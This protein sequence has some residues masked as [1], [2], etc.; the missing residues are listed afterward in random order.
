MT[1]IPHDRTT[2]TLG[3]V[4]D[5]VNMVKQY[6]DIVKVSLDMGESIHVHN[7]CPQCHGNCT[8]G[9]VKYLCTW[10]SLPH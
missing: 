4:N 3:M 2:L 10:E 6:L 1:H 5:R 7:K 8:H 9:I